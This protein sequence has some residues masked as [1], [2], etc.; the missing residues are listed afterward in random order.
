M[1]TC[2]ARTK[3]TPNQFCFPGTHDTGAYQTPDFTIIASNE[4]MASSDERFA[5]GFQEVA[6]RWALSQPGQSVYD[7]LMNGAR[8]LDLRVSQGIDDKTGKMT[9]FL[10]HTFV[11][12]YL[13][14]ALD[15]MVRFL[16]AHPTE[17]LLL[18]IGVYYN[19]DRVQMQDFFVSKLKQYLYTDPSG[20]GK[21]S[22]TIDAITKK[23]KNIIA[24][25]GVPRSVR[26]SLYFYMRQDVLY[27]FPFLSVDNVP[28]KQRYVL[29]NL[30]DYLSR[31]A[32][33]LFQLTYT[34]TEIPIDV[35]ASI[36]ATG[37]LKKFA[38][39]MNPTQLAF[40]NSLTKEQRSVIGVIE[41]DDQV[42]SQ[43]V[44]IAMMLLAERVADMESVARPLATRS[45]TRGSSLPAKQGAVCQAGLGDGVMI[46]AWAPA[47]PTQL[48][49]E[50]SQKQRRREQRR[51]RPGF[52]RRYCCCCLCC[53]RSGSE[54]EGEQPLVPT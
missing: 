37:S 2:S 28:A 31:K 32:T 50:Q 42:N 40:V 8:Y 27:V 15:D 49:S 33:T 24:C 35:V 21:I 46:S 43:N 34:L 47:D 26:S 22:E 41:N 18:D 51:R 9:F 54:S 16:Q 39:K 12:S 25:L 4:A 10:I 30:N 19:T 14:T 13:E 36:F 17:L 53:T 6:T 5:P 52:L 11:V 20:T 44:S 7:Q 23:G 29:Q 38:D 48:S 45:A 3:L 1:A